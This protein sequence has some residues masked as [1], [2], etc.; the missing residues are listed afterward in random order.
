MN[1]S[2]VIEVKQKL[3]L[4]T[5]KPTENGEVPSA[6]DCPACRVEL[7]RYASHRRHYGATKTPDFSPLLEFW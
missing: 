3:C 1:P 5:E 2:S 4:P 6:L 7:Q